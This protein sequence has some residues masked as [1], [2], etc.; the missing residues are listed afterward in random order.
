MTNTKYVI[1]WKK[2]HSEET[3]YV[4]SINEK[5]RRFDPASSIDDAEKYMDQES[6]SM[7]VHK[8]KDMGETENN[9]FTTEPCYYMEHKPVQ[10][11]HASTALGI[12]ITEYNKIIAASGQSKVPVVYNVQ[13]L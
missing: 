4:G 5:E 1:K 7:A 6:A 2:R 8:L 13:K 11:I 9:V 12:S 10:T 3:G